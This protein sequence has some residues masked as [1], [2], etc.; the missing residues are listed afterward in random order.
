PFCDFTFYPH[1][2]VLSAVFPTISLGSSRQPKSSGNC[3][4]RSPPCRSF[5]SPF[6][7]PLWLHH[8]RNPRQRYTDG[9]Y[10]ARARHVACAT[11]ARALRSEKSRVPCLWWFGRRGVGRGRHLFPST[12][13]LHPHK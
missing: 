2:L 9:Y 6:F 3:S 4:P 7:E 11:A 8:R 5:A 10:F 12:S 1:T 13:G